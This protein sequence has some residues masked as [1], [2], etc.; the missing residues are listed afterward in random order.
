MAQGLGHAVTHPWLLLLL[1][2]LA[3]AQDYTAFGPCGVVKITTPLQL[4]EGSEC[5]SSC[6]LD[7]QIHIPVAGA[8][9]GCSA[10]PY[11]VVLF[12]SGF[13]LSSTYYTP[14]VKRL[15]SWGFAVVQYNIALFH[16][17]ADR[18][19]VGFM[20]FLLRH[21][22]RHP[23][24]AG[25]LDLTHLATAGHSRGGKLAALHLAGTP[26]ILTAYLI[27]PV[28]STSYTP[29]SQDD[30]SAV[31]ALRGLNKTVAI[32]GA[33]VSGPCN[34]IASNYKL[35]WDVVGPGSWLEVVPQGGHM[36]FTN[37]SN[38]LVARALDLICHSG[39]ATHVHV[40][41]LTAPA[42]VAWMA[43]TFQR[44]PAMY[45]AAASTQAL[46]ANVSLAPSGWPSKPQSATAKPTKTP[47]QPQQQGV[48]VLQLQRKLLLSTGQD[49]LQKGGVDAA[50]AEGSDSLQPFFEWIEREQE[51]GEITFELKCG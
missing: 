32:T 15:A 24:T 46:P 29:P 17:V 10:A 41:E 19:E 25:V 20:P 21:L 8:G 44:S 34:P 7:V 49:A 12:F 13:Q 11:P 42:L 28:D 45:T 4:P 33:G 14:Y 2:C 40:I 43:T 3:A 1:S 5:G 16:I 23:D 50:A 30:P 27:D 35:F 38:G 48:R 47:H 39:R 36:Q 31:E 37:I 22:E 18:V 51:A 6:T 26:N 9:A